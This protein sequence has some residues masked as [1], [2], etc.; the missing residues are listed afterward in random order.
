MIL[1]NINNIKLPKYLG[2]WYEI[3]RVPY[4]KQSDLKNCKAEYTINRDGTIEVMNTG[5]KI[6]NG[7]R[8]NWEATLKPFKH[9]DSIFLLDSKFEKS[10]SLYHILY[11]TP[12]YDISVVTNG[13]DLVWILSRS[14]EI[15][16]DILK[17]IYDMLDYYGYDS[18]TLMKTIQD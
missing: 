6:K 2:V 17:E 9:F 16:D 10:S 1:N 4:D 13:N 8:D 5:I 7:K 3:A 14:K 15:S 12:E 18:T 11:I